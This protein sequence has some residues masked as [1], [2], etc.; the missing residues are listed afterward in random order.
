MT[1]VMILPVSTANGETTYLALAGDKQS[2]G[3]SAGAALDA[4][5]PQLQE[6][7]SS[8]VVILQKMQPDAYFSATQQQQLTQLMNRWRKQRDSGKGLPPH[9]QKVLEALVEAELLAATNRTNQ[10]ITDLSE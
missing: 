3:D 1:K 7:A 4:L 2:V 9:E 10:L 5:T 8:T 6:T